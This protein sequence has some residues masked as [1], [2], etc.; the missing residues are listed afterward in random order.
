M[1]DLLYLLFITFTI[2]SCH[3]QQKKGVELV[4]PAA[5]QKEMAANKG[6]V[7]DV[8]TPKEYQ[9]GHIAGAVNMHVYDADF[10]KR[11]DSLDKNKTVYVYC[12]AGGRSAEAVEQI[13]AKGFV[14]IVELDGGMDAWNEAGKPVKR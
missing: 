11:I 1:K 13:K 2:T 9:S 14:H 7:I 8:R 10:S 6:Q 5:F 4:S 12:K 3:G